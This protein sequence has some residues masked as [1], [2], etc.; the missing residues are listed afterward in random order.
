MKALRLT[1]LALLSVVLVSAA[2]AQERLICRLADPALAPAVAQDYGVAYTDTTAPAPFVLFT[3]PAG[4]DPHIIQAAM[5][6]DPRVVWAEDDGVVESPETTS[7]KGSVTNVVGD[8]A[9]L[10]SQNQAIL[11]QINWMKISSRRNIARRVRLAILDTGLS[12]Q[13]Q[14]LWGRVVGA[15]NALPDGQGPYDLPGNLDTNRNGTLDDG[16]GHGTMVT[17]IVNLLAP[18]VDLLI[19][20][21]ADSDGVGT[22][23]TVLKGLAYA[24]MNEAEVANVSLG[25]LERLP[26]LSDVLEWT[27]EHQLLVVAAAGNNNLD[28]VLFPSSY[29]KVICVT[30]VDGRD[31]KAV[32]SNWGSD[33]DMAA[34]AVGVQS[35]WW[36]GKAAIW[37]G[38]SFAAPMVAAS[39][40]ESLRRSSKWP[41]DRL[42][43]IVR[44]AGVNIDGLNHDD[45]RG[46][47]GRRLDWLLMETLLRKTPR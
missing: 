19:A 38:T 14:R 35:T 11:R 1:F 25:S 3:I 47:L 36:N 33:A 41:V 43:E 5:A 13:V 9:T 45:Y 39:T 26:A 12:P 23:W 27:D 7:G 4:V 20:R 22:S 34:P 37:S 17:G 24:V 18:D 40:A 30:G 31:R 21:V 15:M 42:R 2:V 8:W 29:S 28:E 6:G 44:R 16:V 32:F 46:K 10:A